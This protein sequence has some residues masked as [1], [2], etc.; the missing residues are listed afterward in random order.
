VAQ[1]KRCA[2]NCGKKIRNNFL[3][4][5]FK[6]T[7]IPLMFVGYAITTIQHGAP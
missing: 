1:S 7:I 2:Q 4:L 5:E 3:G 6:K